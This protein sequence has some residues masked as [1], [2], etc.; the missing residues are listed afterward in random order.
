[1]CFQ[2]FCF[3]TTCLKTL[4][5]LHQLHT[6]SVFWKS[7]GAFSR[8]MHPVSIQ[9]GKGR[10]N[11]HLS[12]SIKPKKISQL[13]VSWIQNGMSAYYDISSI[14]ILWDSNI[15]KNHTQ[16]LLQFMNKPSSIFSIIMLTNSVWNKLK[17]Q[18]SEITMRFRT[19][20]EQ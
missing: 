11:I 20:Y 10:S 18:I 13:V 7:Q 6:L 14:V 1:M 12:L 9:C 4:I 19:P 2:V 15:K 5:N 17:T 3:Q 8:H 16:G